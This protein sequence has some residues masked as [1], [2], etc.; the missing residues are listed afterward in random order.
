MSLNSTLSNAVSGLTVAQAALATTASNVANV[1]TPGYSRKVAE[2]ESRLVAGKGAGAR[3]LDVTRVTDE[4]ITEQ[5]RGQATQLG[6][7]EVLAGIQTRI[8]DTIFGA[9]GDASR[10]V[11][12]KLAELLTSLDRLA[13][14][15]EQVAARSEAI[16]KIEGVLR[17]LDS[18]ISA[19]QTIRHDVDQQL[20]QVIG[21]INADLGELTTIN[22]RFAERNGSADMA[23][24]RD[25]LLSSLAGKIDIQVGRHDDGT[26]EV[27]TRTG[28]VLVDGPPRTIIYA[29]ASSTSSGSSFGPIAIYQSSDIDPKSGKPLAGTR[30]D[31]LVSAGSRTSLTPELAAAGAVQVVSN[32]RGGSLD[33]LL[34]ARDRVLPELAD[35][36]AE[37]GAVIRFS[38]NAAHNAGSAV[39]PPAVLLGSKQGLGSADPFVGSGTAT[40]AAVD[41]VTGKTATSVSIDLTTASSVGDV[42]AAINAGGAP[43]ITAALNSDGRLLISAGAPRQGIAIDSADTVIPVA[44]AAGHARSYGL[45]HYF[46]LNDIIVGGD[47][48]R[49]GSVRADISTDPFQL[50]AARLASMDIPPNAA[51]LGGV[52]DGRGAAALAASLR[53]P[54]GVIA[55]GSLPAY[56]TTAAGYA[57][58]VASLSASAASQTMRLHEGNLALSADLEARVGSLSGVN[59][60]EE[61]SR[62]ILYQQ[63]YSASARIIS[64]TNDLFDELMQIAR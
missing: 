45:S 62:L 32:V 17:N 20:G 15:P 19:V 44:D 47:A 21:S 8:Q 24:R 2:Q 11:A 22:L 5:A 29:P 57:A 42:V 37:L 56:A 7:S 25:A 58:D 43:A 9:P 27:T 55:R 33:G 4:F 14:F 52:G 64:I 3:S 46:G 61:M 40:L 49:A 31:E 6:R 30:S 23:D 51:V 53:G 10:G 48:D 60:D 1:N 54:I 12:N 16:S 50:A 18:D 36:L 34:Q 41:R 63:A 28:S 38:L 59:V 26:V 39:P 13:A 35:Q